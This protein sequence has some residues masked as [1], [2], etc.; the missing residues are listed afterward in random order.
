ML[1]FSEH[2]TRGATTLRAQLAESGALAPKEG[3][4]NA[5]F[6]REVSELQAEFDEVARHMALTGSEGQTLLHEEASRL[7]DRIERFLQRTEDFRDYPAL[8]E[9][10]AALVNE[11]R[12]P[13]SPREG[14][15][16]DLVRYLV[17]LA[18][19]QYEIGDLESLSVL[20]YGIRAQVDALKTGFRPYVIVGAAAIVLALGYG[21][22]RLRPRSAA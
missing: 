17:D 12:W 10:A 22:S 8:R 21:V 15:E 20:S 5:E 4:S 3:F 7:G 1:Q 19:R 14:Q 18:D 6:D 11:R 13:G 16:L 9:E 2:L